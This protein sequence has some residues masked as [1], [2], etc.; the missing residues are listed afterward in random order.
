MRN[1]AIIEDDQLIAQMYRMKLES[2]GYN[3]NVAVNGMTGIEM[4]ENTKPD[5]ILLDLTLPDIEGDVV[6]DGIRHIDTALATPVVILTNLDDADAPKQLAKW[7]IDDYI[8]KANS[9]PRQVVSRVA[10]ILKRRNLGGN[11]S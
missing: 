7:D 10:E 2:E 3:V 8:V 6:L 4:V 5:L 9:T 1:I 11:K